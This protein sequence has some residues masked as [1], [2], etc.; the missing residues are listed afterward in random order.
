[1]GQTCQFDFTRYK[2]TEFKIN[3]SKELKRTCFTVDQYSGRQSIKFNFLNTCSNFIADDC[4]SDAIIK[5]KNGDYVK[6]ITFNN[7][8]TIVTTANYGLN[9]SFELLN[10][11][12]N[13]F[14]KEF[15]RALECYINDS[16][17]ICNL[18]FNFK[19]NKSIK[20][21]RRDNNENLYFNLK[22]DS[23]EVQIEFDSSM[24]RRPFQSELQHTGTIHSIE[25]YEHADNYHKIFLEEDGIPLIVPGDGHSELYNFLENLRINYYE[26]KPDIKVRTD[27]SS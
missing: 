23:Q 9:S 20:L 11:S 6:K 8:Y 18:K 19:T 2:I 4:N 5:A 13:E 27:R 16:T 22:Y 7:I 3:V 26:G 12:M 17:K 14:E 25:K 10:D 15:C 24:H 21:L 1:M